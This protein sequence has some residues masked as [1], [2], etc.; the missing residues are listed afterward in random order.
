[1]KCLFCKYE[2]VHQHGKTAKGVERF[3]Y[4]ACA[5]T[6]TAKFIPLYY[7]RQVN[8]TE[9]HTILPAQRESVSSR[10]TRYANCAVDGLE[11]ADSA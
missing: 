7:R 10:F 2:R 8:A 11:R 1:M 6:F 3:K 9:V 5:Q 4:P